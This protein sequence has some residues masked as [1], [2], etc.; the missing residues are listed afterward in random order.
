MCKQRRTGRGSGGRG[1]QQGVVTCGGVGGVGGGGAAVE[2][3]HGQVEE[4][5]QQV[6]PHRRHALLVRQVRQ[7]GKAIRGGEGGSG[8]GEDTKKEGREE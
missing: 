6:P 1:E 2:V 4:H 5:A 8:G 7:A 3:V